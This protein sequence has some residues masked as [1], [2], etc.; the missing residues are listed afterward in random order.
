MDS[1]VILRFLTGMV[2]SQNQL[3]SNEDNTVGPLS[4]LKQVVQ[5]QST[6]AELYHEY[7]LAFEEYLDGKI[8][9]EELSLIVG[10]TTDGFNQVSLRIN[11]IENAL[12]MMD[13]DSIAA[14]TRQL[15]EREREKLQL[16]VQLQIQQQGKLDGWQAELDRL[17]K[18]RTVLIGKIN[19]ILMEINA[20][21]SEL[22]MAEDM[23]VSV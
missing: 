7:E 4:L 13:Q 1:V 11:G 20:E 2:T 19:E 9:A 16:T 10:I 12:Q 17:E 5:S 18:E 15:Q 22:T 8:Q 23:S 6:R 21:I 3:Q 14:L